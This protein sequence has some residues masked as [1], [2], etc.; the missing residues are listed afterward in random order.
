MATNLI[1]EAV[2]EAE[3]LAQDIAAYRDF[4]ASE[5][6]G[7]FSDEMRFRDIIHARLVTIRAKVG[8]ADIK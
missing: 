7:S 2:P 8:F 5:K 4:L 3:L 1:S 6:K